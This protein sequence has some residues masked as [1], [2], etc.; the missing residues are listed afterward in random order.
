MGQVTK[1]DVIV[2]LSK[3]G[4]SEEVNKLL[5]ALR[6]IGVPLVAITGRVESTLGR[7]AQVVLYAGVEVEACP[8]DLA[9]TA[10]TT[11][12]AQR[13]MPERLAL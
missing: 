12:A 6:R 8:L 10:Y 7:Q 4:E 11:V 9:P 2:A 5:P 13:P 1:N 3:S